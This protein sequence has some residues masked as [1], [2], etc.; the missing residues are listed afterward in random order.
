MQ[1][2]IR[3][4]EVLPLRKG[5]ETYTVVSKSI[6]PEAVKKKKKIKKSWNSSQLCPH[7]IPGATETQPCCPYSSCVLLQGQQ[8]TKTVSKSPGLTGL[9]LRE[10]EHWKNGADK[11]ESPKWSNPGNDTGNSSCTGSI[12]H[13][14]SG[15]SGNGSSGFTEK[16]VWFI[17]RN[18]CNK[19][20]LFHHKVFWRGKKKPTCIWQNKSTKIPQ[21]ALVQHLAIPTHPTDSLFLYI[22]S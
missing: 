3:L 14:S 1:P 11:A 19:F 5:L 4:D 22:L 21:H 20:F 12:H 2:K 15:R 8:G 18:K 13:F 7:R 6:S 9:K 17:K 16:Q 10:W